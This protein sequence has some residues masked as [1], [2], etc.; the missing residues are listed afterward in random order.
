MVEQWRRFVADGTADTNSADTTETAVNTAGLTV[1]DWAKSIIQAVFDL[2]DITQT[3]AESISGFLRIYNDNNTIDPLYFPLPVIPAN[4]AAAAAGQMHFPV[5]VPVLQNVDKNDVI[6]MASAFD[7]ATTGVHVIGGHL[8]LSSD[9]V[10]V[11]I[12]A[13]TM[14]STAIGDAL[15]QSAKVDIETLAG[16]TSALLGIWGYQN[17]GG[18]M[19]AAE[20]TQPYGRVESSL[21][22]WLEQRLPLNHINACLGADS[23]AITKPVLYYYKENGIQLEDYFDGFHKRILGKRPFPVTGRQAFSCSAQHTRDPDDTID[24]IFRLGLI[25]KE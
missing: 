11:R 2:G 14:A 7:L 17:V 6:R 1:P 3:A 24:A 10:P 23:Y 15:A 13:R 16:K 22:G 20:S 8:L 21:P 9:E 19:V 5:T 18:T 12:H 4:L 25:W